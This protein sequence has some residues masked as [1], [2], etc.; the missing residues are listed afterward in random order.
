MKEYKIIRN[1][2]VKK[3]KRLDTLILK[4]EASLKKAPTGRLILSCSKGTVQY[5]HKTDSTQ[6]KGKY[7]SKKNKKLIHAL[8]QKDYDYEFL[9][10]ITEQKNKILKIMRLLPDIEPEEL[11]RN[12][13]ESRRIFIYPH[14]LSDEEY[15]KQWQNV[16]YKGK[17][18]MEDTAVFITENGEKVRSKS[19]KIIA[20]KLYLLG[21]PYRY[22]C[23]LKVRGY[24][25]VYP[26]FTLLNIESREE[27]YMEHFGMMDK[28]EYCQK[29]IL[30]LE[31]YARNGIY[32]GKG[33]IVTFETSAKALDMQIFEKMLNTYLRI[34][35]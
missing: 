1:L 35:Y 5:Y 10:T 26:D 4:A 24:G 29:A 21:I 31:T 13:S 9:R 3:V 18:F 6:K 34:N 2:L 12:V 14:E 33:L 25:V 20:D 19:E 27:I 28:P 30:K 7:I 8:A 11:I 22:E 17:T 15:I 16:V 23:P 32:P